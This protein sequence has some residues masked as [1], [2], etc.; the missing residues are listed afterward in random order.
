MANRSSGIVSV[1]E[2]FAMKK[3]LAYEA[4]FTH[5]INT[6]TRD[7]VNKK[8]TLKQEIR[9]VYNDLQEMKL[10]TG[11]SL[12]QVLYRQTLDYVYVLQ[13]SLTVH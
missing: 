3:N 9:S 4:K 8:E 11:Y 13:L 10:S 7:Y 1:S 6:M 12:D 5:S 2:L